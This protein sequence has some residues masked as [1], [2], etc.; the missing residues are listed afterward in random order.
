[1]TLDDSST[2]EVA[3]Y[4]APITEPLICSFKDLSLP[5]SAS[6]LPSS[7]T[8]GAAQVATE[9][10]RPWL[11]TR[12][13]AT[14][15]QAPRAV[16]STATQRAARHCES[17]HRRS[18]RARPIRRRGSRRMSAATRAG[19]SDSDGSGL[20]GEGPKRRLLVV[21]GGS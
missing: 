2:S 4:E 3:V 1:M 13:A 14:Y 17:R 9:A 21:G 7:D 20:D 11:D 15:V 6:P 12:G 19:P 16:E 5:E 18:S 10:D 8:R